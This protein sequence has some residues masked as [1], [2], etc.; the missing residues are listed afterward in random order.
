M[1]LELIWKLENFFVLESFANISDWV[2]MKSFLFFMLGLKS[3]K[4]KICIVMLMKY[5]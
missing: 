1:K 5:G 4:G 2:E 3:E